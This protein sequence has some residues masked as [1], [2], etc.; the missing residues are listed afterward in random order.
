[1]KTKRTFGLLFAVP[2][3]AVIIGC[4]TVAVPEPPPPAAPPPP[5]PPPPV[6]P[7][8][9]KLPDPH[10]PLTVSILRRLG[11]SVDTMEN[12]G[13]F[14]FVLSGKITLERDYSIKNDKVEEW[15]IPDLEDEHIKEVITINDQT[16]GQAVSMMND[17]GRIILAVC[18]EA[19]DENKLFFSCLEG[20]PEEYFYLEYTPAVSDD[21]SATEEKGSLVY[22]GEVFKLFSSEANPFL[23]I[24]LS[25]RDIDT[26]NSRTAPGRRRN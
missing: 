10:S 25:Q 24:K 18:F 5:P 26:L 8:P 6:R 19:D 7:A 9:I 4:Q 17:R 13:K 16:E 21:Y 20:E 1:M 23:S 2:V 14:E 3:L 11:E 22:G 12:I 15:G